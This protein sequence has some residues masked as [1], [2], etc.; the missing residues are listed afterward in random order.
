MYGY[1]FEVMYDEDGPSVKYG[2]DVSGLISEEYG[3]KINEA[4]IAQKAAK[5]IGARSAGIKRR[6]L[7][8]IIKENKLEGSI[9]KVRPLFMRSTITGIPLYLLKSEEPITAE[10]I[11]KLMRMMFLKG[12][13]R[14]FLEKVKV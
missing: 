12:E 6:M 11:D 9:N 14:T 3:A 7:D 4:T 10:E 8:A 5:R 1:L 13:L 2:M